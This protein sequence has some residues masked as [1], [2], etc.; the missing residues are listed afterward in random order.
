MKEPVNPFQ[1]LV[2]VLAGW[3]NQRQQKMIEYFREEN[4]VLREQLSGRR[5]RFNDDQRRRLAVNAKGL[6]QGTDGDGHAR[7]A[8]DPVGVAS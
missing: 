1:F 4:R 2:I 5:L 7:H 8:R 3:M 6:G